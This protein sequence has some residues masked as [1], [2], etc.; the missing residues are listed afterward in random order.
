MKQ[1]SVHETS[2]ALVCV[3]E[4]TLG[5]QASFKTSWDPEE[6]QQLGN[7]WDG[8]SSGTL[9]STVKTWKS[10][11]IGCWATMLQAKQSY[12]SQ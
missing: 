12:L 10:A 5:P 1:L 2:Y 4:V 7:H 8:W 6:A 11:D 3:Y 9:H